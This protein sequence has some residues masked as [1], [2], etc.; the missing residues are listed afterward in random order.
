M[1]RTIA[2]ATAGAL[3]T[4]VPAS[5]QTARDN[6]AFDQAVQ[7]FTR[8][9]RA[10]IYQCKGPDGKIDSQTRHFPRLV[11]IAR[12]MGAGDEMAI[13]RREGCRLANDAG[14]SEAF[15]GD[16][17]FDMAVRTSDAAWL[18]GEVTESYPQATGYSFEAIVRIPMPPPAARPT[19]DATVRPAASAPGVISPAA[20]EA[21]AVYMK[22]EGT[23]TM[24]GS[25]EGGGYNVCPT[26]DQ[27]SEVLD[28]GK[29][30]PAHL[31]DERMLDAMKARK[32]RQGD[33]ILTGFHARRYV[34]AM[35]TYWYGGQGV[36]NGKTVQVVV[37]IN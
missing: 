37:W 30:A 13:A 32:C 12:E 4:T 25:D 15:S 35:G 33:N 27:V 8:S 18:V 11:A 19:Q 36:E 3:C 16:G 1:K 14:P 22:R 2:V 9:G 7:A 17:L 5:A 24:A 29:A 10:R 26:A 23:R 28:A 31:R 20:R 34:E 21:D 6:A